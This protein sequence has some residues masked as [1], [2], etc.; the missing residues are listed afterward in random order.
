MEIFLNTEY[1]R[2]CMFLFGSIRSPQEPNKRIAT[3][4][5]RR[6]CHLARLRL[7]RPE[8]PIHEMF[9]WFFG[10]ETVNPHEFRAYIVT[11]FMRHK[12]NLDMAAKFL[13][14]KSASTTFKRYWKVD[15]EQ[16]ARDIPFFQNL[17]LVGESA[18][19]T[20]NSHT[21]GVDNDD[22]IVWDVENNNN[23]E[24]EAEE[25]EEEDHLDRQSGHSLLS[26]LEFEQSERLRLQL[27]NQELRSLLELSVNKI[28]NQ[29]GD[30][31]KK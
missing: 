19:Q 31:T 24:E 30:S 12:N 7:H 18:A 13:G 26:A 22:S 10:L 16:L 29:A 25:E 4:V 11:L 6:V 9:A 3:T 2:R 28:T 27:E 20:E 17:N 8:N 1:D 14:H 23:G 15:A 21:N 5:C